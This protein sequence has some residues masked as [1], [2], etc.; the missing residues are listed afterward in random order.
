MKNSDIII[1]D[2][3]SYDLDPM[4][5]LLRELF[6]IEKDFPFNQR[7]QRHGLAA[8]IADHAGSTIKIAAAGGNIVGMCTAQIHISTAEGGLSALIED[9]VVDTA[10]RRKGIGKVLLESVQEWA[11]RRGCLRVQLLADRDNTPALAF[12]RNN[13]WSTTS[14]ICLTRKLS[15]WDPAPKSHHEISETSARS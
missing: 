15:H 12:Y 13:G 7:K 3:R 8:L 4:V 11:L 2:A 1:R 14:M 10:V 9:L 6:S 5:E